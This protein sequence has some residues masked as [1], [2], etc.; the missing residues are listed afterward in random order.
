MRRAHW[1]AH[2]THKD[3]QADKNKQGA[4]PFYHSTIPTFHHFAIPLFHYFIISPFH[5]SN[6][7]PFHYSTCTIPSLFH[8]PLFHSHSTKSRHPA[9][10]SHQC[11]HACIIFGILPFSSL[12]ACISYCIFAQY[13]PMA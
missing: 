8:H 10:T 11:N 5:Y 1:D 4:V 9:P 2:Q 3:M 7:L 13:T 12:H 6:I